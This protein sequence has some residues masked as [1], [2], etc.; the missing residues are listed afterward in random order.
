MNQVPHRPP[1]R[2]PAASL[3]RAVSQSPLRT[4]RAEAV[5]QQIEAAFKCAIDP[6]QGIALSLL[7]AG[8]GYDGPYIDV[9]GLTQRAI[10]VAVSDLSRGRRILLCASAGTVYIHLPAGHPLLA[11]R[12]FPPRPAPYPPTLA[13]PS[14]LRRGVS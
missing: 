2:N 13:V 4:A 10:E 12:V 6:S 11:P 14:A 9:A 3:P 8:F 1:D 5:Y 7:V